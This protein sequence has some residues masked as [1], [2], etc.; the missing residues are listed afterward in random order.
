MN[1]RLDVS[2]GPQLTCAAR[3]KAF[4]ASLCAL[5]PDLSRRA[6]QLTRSQAAA[7]DLVQDTVERALR[8]E[9]TF[10]EGSHLRAWMM[11]ILSNTFISTQRRRNVEYKVLARSAEDP[12]GWTRREA[13]ALLPPLTRAASDAVRELPP[14]LRDALV[15]VDLDDG[16]YK[17]AALELDVPLGTIMSRLH[18]GRA[19][20]ADRLRDAETE[21]GRRTARGQLRG[22][23]A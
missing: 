10:A 11:R 5:L 9:H 4:E 19:R 8:F 23:A 21:D 16:S 14:R 3:K 7:D 18:R 2:S 13:N 6:R 20:L 15:I 17:D 12:N 1:A 22:E